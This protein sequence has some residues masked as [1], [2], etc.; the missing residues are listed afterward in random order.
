MHMS[1]LTVGELEIPFD[2]RTL[3]GF[4]EWA[5]TLDEQAPLV[6]FI[7]GH[8]FV[9]MSQSHKTHS[10]VTTEVNRV[11]STLT[12]EQGTGMYSMAPSWF[13]CEAAGLSAEPDGFF[14][15]YETL[16]AGQLAVHPT[17]EHE[18]VGRP[19][20]VLEVVSRSSRRKDLVEGVVGYAKAGIGEYWIVDAR[21]DEID[22]RVLL[23]RGDAYEAV[24]PDGD[25]FRESPTW[26]RAF[27]LRRVTNPAGLPEFR[28]DVR[29]R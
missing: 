21:G 10:P 6:A 1:T 26:G 4:R 11:L 7:N 20:F 18:M 2:V 8:V 5:A 29:P 13:T 28:L 12:L 19:D 24:A 9:D 27:R 3:E 17:R 22:F 16:R 25:G 15:R 23:L 14:V